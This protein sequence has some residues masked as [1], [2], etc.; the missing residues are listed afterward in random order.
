MSDDQSFE[1]SCDRHVSAEMAGAGFGSSATYNRSTATALASIAISLK[2][3][4]DAGVDV[5]TILSSP[6][7]T[8]E[9]SPVSRHPDG[10][11]IGPPPLDIDPTTELEVEIT[12]GR[13]TV[14]LRLAAMFLNLRAIKRWRYAP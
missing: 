3:L 14:I 11:F 1:P 6:I 2:R 8:A 13:Q 4:A 12:D 7:V 5:L 10:W 9:P